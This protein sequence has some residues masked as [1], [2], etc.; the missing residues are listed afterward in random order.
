MVRIA[1]PYISVQI[2]SS[3]ERV[4]V[5]PLTLRNFTRLCLFTRAARI[6]NVPVE[7]RYYRGRGIRVYIVFTLRAVNAIY[8]CSAMDS[9]IIDVMIINFG[10]RDCRTLSRTGWENAVEQ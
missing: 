7:L 1:Y 8:E 10:Y 6:K 5:P 3:Q 2:A 9:I 4:R